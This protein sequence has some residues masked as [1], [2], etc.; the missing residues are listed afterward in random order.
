M[1][2]EDV[3]C[4]RHPLIGSW[5]GN[6]SY[7]VQRLGIKLPQHIHSLFNLYNIKYSNVLSLRCIVLLC[8]AIMHVVDTS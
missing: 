6:T 7:L 2:I 1:Y 3:V 5:I 8:Y 4:V